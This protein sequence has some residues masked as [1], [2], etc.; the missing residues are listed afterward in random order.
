MSKSLLEIKSL[1]AQNQ[2]SFRLSSA[3]EAVLEMKIR[4]LRAALE[5][6]A[7]DDARLYEQEIGRAHD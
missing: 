4:K 5:W 2:Y 1:V 3:R 6:Y 7:A